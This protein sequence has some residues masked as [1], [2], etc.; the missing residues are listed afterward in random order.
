MINSLL[1]SY[2]P[3]TLDE[4]SGTSNIIRMIRGLL[5]DKMPHLLLSG[6]PGTGKTTLALAIARHFFG[7]FLRK[8]T[9]ELNASD[10]RGISI[11]RNKV[12]IFAQRP[13]ISSTTQT[14]PFKIIIMD[15]ADSMTA[16]AQN[17]LRRIIENEAVS[18][19]FIFICNYSSKINNAIK[20]RCSL[21][22][23][24]PIDDQ[25]ICQR[26]RFIMDK[27][28]E[29]KYKTW[30]KEKSLEFLLEN[31]TK[32]ANGD[33]RA[34]VG[35]LEKFFLMNGATN[36]EHFDDFVSLYKE[37][38]VYK[39]LS[40]RTAQKIFEYCEKKVFIPIYKE[41]VNY[42]KSGLSFRDLLIEM[43]NELVKVAK[44]QD[45][46]K[47]EVLFHISVAET[48]ILKRANRKLIVL[49]LISV[50]LNLV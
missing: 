26:L 14:F 30:N 7:T 6:P 41:I 13:I 5:T 22:R 8:N 33:L 24:P 2:R 18:T 31:W 32:E 27:E 40:Q 15:E 45:Y 29:G 48:E 19:R 39:K 23:F 46:I 49:K 20:S 50:I 38:L 3:K 1:E 36:L 17:A 9:L 34:A 37:E 10:E 43:A 25:S 47:A 21:F 28:T 16:E 4:I 44:I 35:N 42:E 12:K 11:I